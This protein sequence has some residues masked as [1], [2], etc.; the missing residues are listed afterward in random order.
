[1]STLAIYL[2]RILLLFFDAIFR[3]VK[4]DSTDMKSA[5]LAAGLRDQTYRTTSSIPS[6]LHFVVMASRPSASKLPLPLVT[7]MILR[8]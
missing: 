4:V 8:V 1:V 2:D 7:K 5:L 6:S 3:V